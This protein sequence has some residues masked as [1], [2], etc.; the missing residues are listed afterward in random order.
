MRLALLGATGRTG[1]QL[2][3][4]AGAAGHAVRA[5][6]RTPGAL[7]PAPALDVVHGDV[8]DPAAVDRVVAGADAVLSAL[9]GRGLV[10]PG[11]ARSAGMRLVVDAMARHGVARVLAVGGG[12]VL[13]L[14]GVGLRSE[15]PGYPE[16]FRQV[17][18]EHHGTWTA[19]RESGL[20]W[21]LVCTPDIVDGPPTGTWR[22]LADLMPEGGRRISTGDVAR[23]MLE[24][25]DAGAYVRRRVGLA[26]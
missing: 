18:R 2:V 15:R 22:A 25:L 9:G 5:L 23:F 20:A 7:A 19:L 8:L 13:D 14:P 26:Y 12:G 1:R 10:D 3:A 6:V 16:A 4:Q 21:T 24:E 17:T 11:V